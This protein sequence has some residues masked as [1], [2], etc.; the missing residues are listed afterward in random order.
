MWDA[1]KIL[2]SDSLT[3]QY[4]SFSVWYFL[5]SC[6]PNSGWMVNIVQSVF[7][8]SLADTQPI[9][10][11]YQQ[12]AS[13]DHVPLYAM[14][15]SDIFQIPMCQDLFPPFC[16]YFSYIL[17]YSDS[18]WVYNHWISHLTKPTP[19]VHIGSI[20]YWQFLGSCVCKLHI[21]CR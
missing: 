20:R 14:V 5:S 7:F 2:Q 3:I 10:S 18:F 8:A 11:S 19:M 6:M 12:D 13:S 9:V 4:S 17:Y 16:W 21:W 15:Q 1:L